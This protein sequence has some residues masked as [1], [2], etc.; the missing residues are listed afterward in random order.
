M[1]TFYRT[2]FD[3]IPEKSITNNCIVLDLDETLVHT[4]DE[5]RDL[6]K[7]NLLTNPAYHDLRERLYFLKLEDVV[8]RKGTGVKSNLW[9]ITRPHVKEFL[10]FCFSY[11]KIVA[12]WS[13]GRQRYVDAIVNILFQDIAK[14]HVTFSWKDCK[15]KGESL[16]GKPL[17]KMIATVPGLS[18]H[19]SLKNTYILDDRLA[20]F[21]ENPG[22]GILIPVYDPDLSIKS[23]R[24]DDNHLLQFASWLQNPEVL[25][26][27]DLRSVKKTYIWSSPVC[28][29][30]SPCSLVIVK[31]D[32]CK[33]EVVKV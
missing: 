3:Q 15:V 22:N 18:D 14:P 27:E 9:G 30:N 8:E 33:K 12:V 20:N 19:M 7:L 31:E 6:H 24:R 26:S 11:F 23:I 13:A 16:V 1:S 29:L 32:E 4:F 28:K 10:I 5:P 21:M 2:H 25:Q 17:S